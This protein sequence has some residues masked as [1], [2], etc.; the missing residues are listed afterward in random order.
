MV[1]KKGNVMLNKGG[2]GLGCTSIKCTPELAKPSLL[3]PHCTG[4]NKPASNSTDPL[5]KLPSSPSCLAVCE[6]S[7]QRERYGTFP[8]AM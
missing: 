1:L 8:M 4:P 7:P 6:Q 5:H 2:S 3:C